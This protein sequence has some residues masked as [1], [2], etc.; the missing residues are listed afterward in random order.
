MI[1]TNGPN[2]SQQQKEHPTK[3]QVKLRTDFC[4]QCLQV[5]MTTREI[6]Q[7]CDQ[8]AKN[9][10]NDWVLS[11]RRVQ[12]YVARARKNL[13]DEYSRE[14]SDMRA[15]SGDRYVR[16]F[17][18]AMA[19]AG[20]PG[21]EFDKNGKVI[22]RRDKVRALDSARKAIDSYCRLFGLNKPEQVMIIEPDDKWPVDDSDM[23]QE[24][25]VAAAMAAEILEDICLGRAS[26]GGLN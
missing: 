9:G 14:P 15:E 3:A 11:M 5:G 18:E 24:Q 4:A 23:T 2:G 6:K 16:V 7:A 8:R 20:R 10:G 21:V 26:K 12:D 22:K 1:E 17:R 13:Q 19:E 25:I